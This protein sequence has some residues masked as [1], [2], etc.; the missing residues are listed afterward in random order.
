VFQLGYEGRVAHLRTICLRDILDHAFDPR[1]L[2][3]KEQMHATAIG[4]TLQILKNVDGQWMA[5][6]FGAGTLALEN[7]ID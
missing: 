3:Q 2:G 4:S 6:V 1:P 5:I 7:G